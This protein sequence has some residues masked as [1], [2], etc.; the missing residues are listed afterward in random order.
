MASIFDKWDANT[1]LEGLQKDIQEAQEN[2]GTGN[3]KEVP[4]GEYEV[5]VEQMELKESKNGRPM[6]SIWFNVLEGEFKGQKIFMNQVV[7]QGFQF[8]IVNEL[9][10]KMVSEMDDAPVIEFNGYSKY[11]EL[12]LDVHEAITDNFE[13]ALDYGETSKGFKTFEITEVFV[14]E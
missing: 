12:I 9:L 11:A 2:G 6:V 8:H 5:S 3:F 10:R 14:L 7:E 1:D 4:L 13:Y